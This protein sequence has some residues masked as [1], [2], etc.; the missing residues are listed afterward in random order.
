MNF[1]NGDYRNKFPE[2][3]EQ[4][5]VY[6]IQ[7]PDEKEKVVPEAY[8]LYGMQQPDEKEKATPEAR[9][10]YGM[11]QPEYMELINDSPIS[12]M[13]D[14]EAEKPSPH[15]VYGIVQPDENKNQMPEMPKKPFQKLMEFLKG[16]FKK[17]IDK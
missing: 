2:K 7:Q 14:K 17:T 4:R 13:I 12:E 10:L 3:P 1:P 5:V 15:L 11:Q 16:I 6:G 9:V 8:I